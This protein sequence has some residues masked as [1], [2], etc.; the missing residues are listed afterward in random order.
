MPICTFKSAEL[1]RFF[2]LKNTNIEDQLLLMISFLQN[3]IWKMTY[4]LK[5]F[6]FFVIWFPSFGKRYK[7]NLRVIFNRWP[8]LWRG[9]DVE[10]EIQILKELWIIEEIVNT[11][12]CHFM[13]PCCKLKLVTSYLDTIYMTLIINDQQYTMWLMT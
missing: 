10:C 11:F 5:M 12:L 9:F 2:S 6:P 4:F 13:Y 7:S 8:K 3:N 1:V